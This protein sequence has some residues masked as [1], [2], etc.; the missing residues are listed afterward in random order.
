MPMPMND[1]LALTA[2]KKAEKWSWWCMLFI[3]IL[4]LISGMLWNA[5]HPGVIVGWVIFLLG[6]FIP[7]KV[8]FGK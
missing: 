5:T 2:Y 7:V 8:F 6:L 1:I 4:P 3:G